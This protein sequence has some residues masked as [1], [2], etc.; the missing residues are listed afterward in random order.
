MSLL[1][2]LAAGPP[3]RR[4]RCRCERT[5]ANLRGSA[6]DTRA[7]VRTG[8]AR[9]LIVQILGVTGHRR[10]P[11]AVNTGAMVPGETV[12]RLVDPADTAVPAGGPA[13]QGR[14][15]HPM[16]SGRFSGEQVLTC[17]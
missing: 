15:G 12:R 1:F 16:V 6:P 4:L 13:E 2:T 7:V 10:V 3:V 14:G 8:A 5:R 17:S 11:L 9:R